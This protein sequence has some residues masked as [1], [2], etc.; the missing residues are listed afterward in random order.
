MNAPISDSSA[1]LETPELTPHQTYRPWVSLVLS[2]FVTGLGQFLSGERAAGL[3]WFIGILCLQ[4][5]MTWGLASLVIPGVYPGICIGLAALICWIWM[6]AKSWRRIPR[7]SFWRWL[8][9]V[10]AIGMV[11]YLT[12]ILA[13]TFFQPFKVP[14]GGMEPTIQGGKRLPAGSRAGGDHVF[15]VKYAYWFSEPRRGDIVVFRT[16]DV[17]PELPPG[18]FFVKRIAGIAGDD[19]SVNEGKLC[20]G[21]TSVTEPPILASLNFPFMPNGNHLVTNDKTYR[22]PASS[23]FVIGDNLTNSFDSRFFGTVP[24]HAIIGRV[25]KAYWPW[26]RAGSLDRRQTL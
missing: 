5:L 25:S 23:F 1:G 18:E 16:S 3:R 9:V 19:L 4:L 21:G 22:V 11:H 8:F 10:G 20:A 2:L 7:L 14:T 24:R 26:N 6:L 13:H 15:V 17:S 12:P